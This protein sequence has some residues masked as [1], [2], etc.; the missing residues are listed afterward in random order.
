MTRERDPDRAPSA[1]PGG[2]A[3][4]ALH[5]PALAGFVADKARLREAALARGGVRA[6]LHEFV[7]S[8]LKQGWAC[9]FAALAAAAII[10]GSGLVRTPTLDAFRVTLPGQLFLGSIFSRW[11]LCANALGI[12]SAA[13]FVGFPSS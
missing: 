2:R 10:D 12:G 13:G 4:P 5:W 8:G 1:V 7:P 9:L 3:S 11:N 6:G